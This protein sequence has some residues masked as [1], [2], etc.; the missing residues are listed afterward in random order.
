MSFA[1][2]GNGISFSDIYMTPVIQPW[3]ILNLFEDKNA[4][5]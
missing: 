5:Q 3:T 1:V 2:K 4:F